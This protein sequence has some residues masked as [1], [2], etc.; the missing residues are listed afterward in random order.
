MSGGGATEVAKRER[1]SG[2]G[3]G[4]GLRLVSAYQPS[5]G[6]EMRRE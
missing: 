5:W 6:T 2:G 1:E 3:V 4:G